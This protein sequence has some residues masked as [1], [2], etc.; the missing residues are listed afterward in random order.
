MDRSAIQDEALKEIIQ[1]Y[2]CGVG[3]SMGVGKT[4]LALKHADY[5]DTSNSQY[6]VVVPKKSI[7]KS[8]EEDAAKHGYSHILNKITFTTYLSLKKKDT[9]YNIVYLD[10]C[11]N[12][13][14]SHDNW[15]SKFSGRILGLTGTP[16]IKKKSEKYEMV[17]KYCPIHYQ[18]ITDTAISDNILNDYRIFVHMLPLDNQ[19]LFV[20]N[21][22][23][24]NFKTTEMKSYEYWTNRIDGAYSR[25]ESMTTRVMR[26]KAM[27]VF[28]S[29][30][31][32]AMRLLNKIQD[33]CILFCNTQ[34]QADKLCEYSYH[35]GNEHSESN[36][37]MFKSGRIDKLSCVLQLNEGVN[38]PNLK[39]GIIMHAYGNERKFAQRL[40]RLL[41]LNPN[42][43]ATAHILC[44]ENT[45]DEEW[46]KNSLEPFD[47]SKIKYVQINEFINVVS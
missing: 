18:Y 27:Q 19:T 38:I 7:I 35:S 3:I 5:F 11:H 25:K 20:V 28:P 45:I 6:L 24:K 42:D 13:L 14:Y 36:L 46:V 10:E 44:Y 15:L 37:D 4:L 33:K 22:K 39:H 30:E 23:N 40:G 12:L 9:N 29:K 2:R 32:Y 34:E 26:M 17:S 41:R 1:H 31:R 16:P 21:S 47:P 43:Q 8:W